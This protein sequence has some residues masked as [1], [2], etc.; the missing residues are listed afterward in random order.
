[1]YRALESLRE[2]IV[3]AQ[4]TPFIERHV[5]QPNDSWLLTEVRGIEQSLTIEAIDCTLP[6]AEI[7]RG[8]TFGPL[9]EL[10]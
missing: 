7:Y 6:L 5:R 9:A 3:V 4:E 8:V 2:Y 10:A 1:L